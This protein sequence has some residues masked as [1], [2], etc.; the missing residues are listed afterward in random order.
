MI[1]EWLAPLVER[2]RA[3]L[4]ESLLRPILESGLSPSEIRAELVDLVDM[5]PTWTTPEDVRPALAAEAA[6]LAHK[7]LNTARTRWRTE[8]TH[9]A[10]R[11]LYKGWRDKNPGAT[12]TA[13][14][15]LVARATKRS[16]RQI[17]RY[18]KGVT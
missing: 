10:V 4:P 13:I 5:D 14:M 7:R 12:K 3:Q 2:A 15:L 18:L 16:L 17:Q 1:P 11:D 6:L 9:D 8:L